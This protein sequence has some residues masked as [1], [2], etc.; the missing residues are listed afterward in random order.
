MLPQPGN[1]QLWLTEQPCKT[2]GDLPASS[3]EL[4]VPER[5]GVPER[6]KAGDAS[7]ASTS[8]EPQPPST[9]ALSTFDTLQPTDLPQLFSP[10]QGLPTTFE[11][12][13]RAISALSTSERAAEPGNSSRPSVTA[14]SSSSASSKRKKSN[15]PPPITGNSAY[16]GYLVLGS[17]LVGEFEYSEESLLQSQATHL[18]R[19]QSTR[20]L[21]G[22]AEY[23]PPLQ[24]RRAESSAAVSMPAPELPTG[25]SQSLALFDPHSTLVQDDPF[26]AQS[27][28][29]QQSTFSPAL[30]SSGPG[31]FPP[32]YRPAVRQQPSHPAYPGYPAYPAAIAG[33]RTIAPPFILPDAHRTRSATTST[34]SS[35]SG[36]PQ[37]SPTSPGTFQAAT[38]PIRSRAT[39][40]NTSPTQQLRRQMSRTGSFRGSFVPEEDPEQLERDVESRPQEVHVDGS[41]TVP[42]SHIPR[43]ASI[44]LNET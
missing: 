23:R 10:L 28:P 3:L 9:R 41:S 13:A 1:Y 18:H 8:A 33:Y 12:D 43:D 25:H 36:R 40:R 5:L 32:S 39:S 42:I 20:E 6:K 11:A 38:S 21:A 14:R 15:S 34:M 22:R 35:A 17:F 7:K 37:Y 16:G 44:L 2:I 4:P 30:P 31:F 24:R 19:S 29:P 26:L 27:A